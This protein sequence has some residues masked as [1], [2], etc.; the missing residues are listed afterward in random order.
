LV[1]RALRKL[2]LRPVEQWR[3][4]LEVVEQLEALKSLGQGVAVNGPVE[5][6][7]PRQVELGDDVC[8]NPGL[9]VRGDGG[10]RIGSH[11]H[12][13]ID[14]EIL[15]SNHNFDQPAS[16]PYDEVR[17][18]RDVEIGDCAWIGDR[19]VIVPG[20]KVGEG[21]VLA[22][23]AVVTRDVPAMAVVGGSPAKVIRQRDETSYRRL[24]ES[25]SYLGWPRDFHLV[26]GR[27]ARLRR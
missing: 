1:F 26:N 17:I 16:L 2:V 10:L 14:V 20:V 4:R 25:A 6:G 3:G 24:R 13:G 9:K 5:F 8:I 23:G 21:A 22:A 27:E 15:T 12:F 19:V 7:N 11:V 18:A